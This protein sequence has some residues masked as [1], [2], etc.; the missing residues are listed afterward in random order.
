MT[1]KFN[2]KNQVEGKVT[3]KATS[4]ANDKVID[5]LTLKSEDTVDYDVIAESKLKI[6]K[7]SKIKVRPIATQF[8]LDDDVK[9]GLEKLSKQSR[10]SKNEIANTLLRFAIENSVVTDWWYIERR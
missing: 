7:K 1:N 6:K 2:I 3:N 8:Y 4:K 5:N 10:L 9:A